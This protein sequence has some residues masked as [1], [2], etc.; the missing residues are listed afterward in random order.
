MEIPTQTRTP[1]RSAVH[2]L[3]EGT[4]SQAEQLLELFAV[5]ALLL[6]EEMEPGARAGA[7][8][9]KTAGAHAWGT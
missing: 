7:T 8:D 3:R 2:A 4:A 5:G 6:A 1:L 9:E